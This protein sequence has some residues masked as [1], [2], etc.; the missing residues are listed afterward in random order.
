MLK[1]SSGNEIR[2]FQVD[3]SGSILMTLFLSSIQSQAVYKRQTSGRSC[4]KQMQQQQSHVLRPRPYGLEA[5]AD[6][7][8]DDFTDSPISPPKETTPPNRLL[9]LP[10]Q[11]S[12][13]QCPNCRK[14]FPHDLLEN[15]M[16]DCTGDD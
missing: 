2:C 10:N 13:L 16:R 11:G 8:G 15:H 5:C 14:L 7:P 4:T 3:D 12:Q 6:G 9:Y 1:K